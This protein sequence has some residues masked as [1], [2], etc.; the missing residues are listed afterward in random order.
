MALKSYSTWGI[1]T[2]NVHAKFVKSPFSTFEWPFSHYLDGGS[3]MVGRFNMKPYPDSK[4]NG[5]NMWPILGQQVDSTI[6]YRGYDKHCYE[7]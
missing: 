1:I 6:K 3:Q 7:K 4:V 2:T 5:A